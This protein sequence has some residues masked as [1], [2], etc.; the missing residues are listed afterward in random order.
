M[1]NALT[2]YA[3][4]QQNT[5]STVITQNL[6][7]KGQVPLTARKAATEFEATFLA[8]MFRQMIKGIETDGIMGGGQAE[9][10]Y[11][12]LMVDEMSKSI[13]QNGGVGIADQLYVELVKQQ[14]VGSH[15]APTPNN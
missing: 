15:D 5:I 4:L 12:D 3:S 10:I 7:L 13:A 1:I 9:K 11:R 8:Q 14:E 6:A 2:N